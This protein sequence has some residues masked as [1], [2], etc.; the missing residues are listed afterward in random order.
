VSVPPR[1]VERAVAA[2]LGREPS[3]WQP[4][5]AGHTHAEKWLVDGAFVKAG[6]E[7]SARAQIEREA[8][9]LA[10]LGDVAY[11]PRVHGFDVVDEWA[12]L[13]LEDL[14]GAQWPPP[15]PDRGGALLAA[16]AEVGATPAPP[17]LRRHDGERPYGTYWSRVAADPGPVVELGVCSAAWLE[18][19]LPELDAAEARV[20]L[21]GDELVHNDVWAGN[22]CHTER[23]AV[24]IDW[25]DA[26]VGDRRIDLAYALLSIRA[27]DAEPPPVDFADEAA[28]AAYLA[29]ADGLYASQPAPDWIA[30]GSVLRAGWLHDFAY[31]LRWAA[32][33]LGLPP[34][35][36]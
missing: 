15:Y 1:A 9:T 12:V 23:G 13:V 28:Y 34:P 26:L 14:S 17:F 11:V 32:A 31:A 22:V 24:L 2:A 29:G 6:N 25:A 4:V 20:S 33:L 19:A 35:S 21:A 5:V 27:A 8:R 36:R 18:R 3:S 10:A 30:H 16:V 7:S